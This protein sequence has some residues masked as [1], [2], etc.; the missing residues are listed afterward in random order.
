MNKRIVLLVC[1]L[2]FLQLSFGKSQLELLDKEYLNFF[3][4]KEFNWKMIY[5]SFD[6]ML[7][8]NGFAVKNKT[9][10]QVYHSFL[11]STTNGTYPVIERTQE[12]DLLVLELEK[13]GSIYT[14]FEINQQKYPWWYD[15]LQN[16]E[17]LLKKDFSI[18]NRRFHL[19]GLVQEYSLKRVSTENTG[20]LLSRYFTEED[21]SNAAFQKIIVCLMSWQLLPSEKKEKSQAALIE[22]EN[23][24]DQWLMSKELDWSL[25]KVIFNSYMIKS[26]TII[27]EANDKM[28]YLNFFNQIVMENKMK[29]IGY[30][31]DWFSQLTDKKSLYSEMYTI[32][33]PIYKKYKNDLE[34]FDA[35]TGL[36]SI[37]EEL[38]KNPDITPSI[39][40]GGFRYNYHEIDVG[41]SVH[42]KC[43]MTILFP[44][45]ING[46]N[47]K[48]IPEIVANEEETL[49]FAEDMPEFPGGNQAMYKYLSENIKYPTMAMESGISGRVYVSFIVEK[50]GSISDVKVMRGIGGGCDKEAVRVVKNMPKW[51]PGK[52][53]G[54][55]VRV[56]FT[57][58][59]NFKLQ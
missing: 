14:G 43:Y 17:I 53:K 32:V 41:M 8:S 47:I 12:T 26:W 21:L 7:N 27:P 3:K 5:K 22:L 15:R 28:N 30:E 31:K 38:N 48:D 58:P 33:N 23:E 29:K 10:N 6:K 1:S 46:Y 35:L 39:L 16:S 24:L 52:Q 45:L 51:T 37:L 36:N 19:S 59:I 9:R 2:F 13:L 4:E 55:A 25:M 54:K 34:R 11:S 20:Y 56:K 49:D 50:D 44:H 57:L 42:Q 40:A 18:G